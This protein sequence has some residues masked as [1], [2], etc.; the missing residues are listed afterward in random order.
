MRFWKGECS[1]AFTDWRGL[2]Y[3]VGEVAWLLTDVDATES[4]RELAAH[5]S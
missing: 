2:H 1:R 3:G 4:T 5:R